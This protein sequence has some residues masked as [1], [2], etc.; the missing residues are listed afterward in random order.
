MQRKR[1]VQVVV[2]VLALVFFEWVVGKWADFMWFSSLEYD[3]VFWRLFLTRFV[4]GA[5][6]FLVFFALFQANFW[7]LRRSLPTFQVYDVDTQAYEAFIAP[8]RRIF[9]STAAK[10]VTGVFSAVFAFFF[11]VG[12]STNWDV[13]QK[14]FY[15]QPVGRTDPILGKDAAFYMF[16]L[17]VYE[18]LQSSRFSAFVLMLIICALVYFLLASKEFMKDSWRV[19]SPVK[20]H[21]ASLIAGLLVLK[22]GDYYLSI[23]SLLTSAQ[24][25]FFGAGYTDVHANI[26]ALKILTVVA[27]LAALLV[28]VSLV[29][30]KVLPVATGVGVLVVASVLVG[31]V[32]PA[33]VQKFQVEPNEF[34]REKEYIE[35][36]IDATRYAYGLEDVKPI[37]VVDDGEDKADSNIVEDNRVTLSNVRLWDFRPIQQ[38]YNQMQQL[39][40]YYSF[41]G[42]NVDRYRFGDDYRQVMIS[43]RE[44]D[45][46]RLSERARTWVNQ[47][48][49]YTHGY[50]A[51]ISPVNEVTAEGRPL[52]LLENIPPQAAHPE[53]E[54]T[55]PEIYYGELTDDIVIVNTNIGEFD[56]PSGEENIYTNYEGDGGVKLTPI[57]RLL[58]A[59][60]FKD[61]RMVLSSDITS[62]SR[63]LY[64]RTV[65]D[66]S[67]IAPYLKFDSD[68]YPVVVDGRIFWIV[69]AYTTSSQYPYSDMRNGI[70][71]TRNSVKVVVDAYNG[72]YA[73]YVIDPEDPVV[74]VYSNIYPDLYR[75]ISE[76][77]EGLREHIRYP[78]DLFSL[79]AEVFAEYHVQDAR[80]FYN[81]EDEWTIPHE[82][83]SDDSQALEPYYTMMRL[84]GEEEEEFVLV[85]PYT[86]MNRENAV[87]WLAARCDGEHYG[88]M[89][90]DVFPKDVHAYG[91]MQVEASIDQDS[92]ISSQ[93]TLWNQHGSQIIRGNLITVPLGGQL[94][95]VEPLFLQAKESAMPELT[96]V[97]AFY[98]GRVVMERDLWSAVNI[99]FG[100]D[101]Q[102]DTEEPGTEEPGPEQPSGPQ[103]PSSLAQRANQLFQEAENALKAGDWAGYGKA[104]DELGKVLEEML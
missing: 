30:G 65:Q 42:V 51:V 13:F 68:P 17:P 95:Y 34:N 28:F 32:Y 12:V 18:L 33:A 82:K 83:Y 100:T 20:L 48:L 41:P 21:L 96:R 91:P 1:L 44:L 16:K 52:Y 45:Q 50:G 6:I 19:F 49:Q 40:R 63:I 81:R 66:V 14:F 46:D 87:A 104:I 89:V 85:L 64:Q 5:V 74:G 61:M 98:D 88:E 55:R 10:F 67:R 59:L 77:P 27:I 9:T 71:Y 60:H 76:M 86:P 2:I 47:R 97:I 101:E 62:E 37:T 79:Q 90:I 84:P 72:E 31:G 7:Y 53:I 103:A 11:A 102:P 56:Y 4:V 23:Y 25:S 92:D 57:R 26:P 24:G 36:N 54:I 94:L 93:L 35:Y 80:V 75:P 70:N 99:L 38:V 73:F 43:V 3:R 8:L 58:Y 69:D 15:A 29:R 22:A 78:V 39:R